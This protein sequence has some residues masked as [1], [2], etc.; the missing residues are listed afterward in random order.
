MHTQKESYDFGFVLRTWCL[1]GFSKFK[2]PLFVAIMG[3]VVFI[4]D[5]MQTNKRF[6]RI[7]SIKIY[8]F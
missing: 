2:D 1:F 8:I 4:V 5:A 3:G 7:K 6:G